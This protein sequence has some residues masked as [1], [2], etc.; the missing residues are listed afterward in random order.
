MNVVCDCL[1]V[2]NEVLI[3]SVFRREDDV[4]QLGEEKRAKMVPNTH[5]Q[6][7]VALAEVLQRL[8]GRVASQKQARKDLVGVT[9]SPLHFAQRW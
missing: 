1:K 8:A 2:R 6:G 5:N 3:R 7:N 4:V 9:S